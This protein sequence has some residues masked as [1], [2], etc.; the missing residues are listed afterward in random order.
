MCRKKCKCR[1][2]EIEQQHQYTSEIRIHK[3]H[4]KCECTYTWRKDRCHS[5]TADWAWL[6]V[7]EHAVQKAEAQ[8]QGECGLQ[9]A[10][11]EA[12]YLHLYNPETSRRANANMDSRERRCIKEAQKPQKSAIRETQGSI[13]H[14]F[15]YHTKFQCEIKLGG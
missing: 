15:H 12:G 3:S 5:G 4:S 9:S 11:A 1:G 14:L 6:R 8:I 2:S 7:W 13:D 10:P